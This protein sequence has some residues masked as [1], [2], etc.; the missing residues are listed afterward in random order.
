M[1]FFDPK[2]FELNGIRFLRK[3][4]TESTSYKADYPDF[5]LVKTGDMI[6]EYADRLANRQI[7]SLLEL[8]I[9]RGGSVA[10]FS[11][12]LKPKRHMA[13]DIHRGEGGLDTFATIVNGRA[14]E[15][16]Q[17]YVRYDI[18]QADTATIISA[19]ESRFGAEAEFDLI[20]DDAS[21]NYALTLQAFNG[22][23]PRVKPGGIYAIEDWGWGQ[24]YEGG[25]QEPSNIEYAN[26][27]LSNLILFC[28]LAS[29]TRN[30]GISKV[31]ITPDTVFVYRDGRALP[32][33]YRIESSFPTRGRE[34]P[35]L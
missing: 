4:G 10:F 7:D 2:S 8:G 22:L 28:V 5:I 29:T 15:E 17:L 19:Y 11:E 12:Y 9:L 18:S 1:V 16:R 35:L 26:P 24:W 21:H 3:F 14:G 6:K 20:I 32:E 31:D 33:N 30:A 23:F 34:F 27:A 25:Y 13:V